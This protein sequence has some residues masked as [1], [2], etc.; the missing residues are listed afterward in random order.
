MRAKIFNGTALVVSRTEAFQQTLHRA[1]H[2][3]GYKMH[4]VTTQQE[5]LQ[6]L[7]TLI[8][9]F[10]IVDR[11]DS[12]FGQLRHTLQ[13]RTPILTAS[14]HPGACDESHCASDLDDGATRAVCN[15]SPSVLVALAKAAV[16]RCRMHQPPADHF[17][18]GDVMIDFANYAV[19]V[20]TTP[21]SIT[22]TQFRILR[23][24]A[25]AP[26]YFLSRQALFNQVWGEGFAIGR[27]TLDVNLCSLRRM[28]RSGGTSPDFIETVI[29]VGFKLRLATPLNP[30]HR[31]TVTPIRSQ[32]PQSP[33]DSTWNSPETSAVF[34]H[35]A[36]TWST[37]PGRPLSARYQRTPRASAV[38][39]PVPLHAETR[40]AEPP[41]CETS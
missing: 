28:L 27:H 30:I 39:A 18:A 13:D 37:R 2:R 3:A 22:P 38:T 25:V 33:V 41:L 40:Y 29:G 21:I 12:G 35:R 26:G 9:T 5:G 14:H 36:V 16:R 17:V 32:M 20:G 1:L 8:P 4:V 11:T 10:V 7:R 15:A 24:L 6:A 19:T 31:L 23:S 34:R